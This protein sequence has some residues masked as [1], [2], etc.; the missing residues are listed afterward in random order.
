MEKKLLQA[1]RPRDPGALQRVCVCVC[2]HCGHAAVAGAH[3]EEGVHIFQ[4]GH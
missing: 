4:E 2:M 1:E 3:D